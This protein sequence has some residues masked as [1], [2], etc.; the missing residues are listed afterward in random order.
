MKKPLLSL[1]TALVLAGCGGSNGPSNPTAGFDF[2]NATGNF[3]TTSV[4]VERKFVFVL[5]Q[6]DNTV[7]GFFIPEFEEEGHGHA[8][9][10]FL[11]QEEEGEIEF[12]EL[13]GSPYPLTGGT[14]VDLV[15]DP[16]GRYLV[17]VDSAGEL[18]SYAIDGFTGLL[19]LADQ[20]STTVANPRRLAA[21]S[22]GTSVAVLGDQISIHQ[23][24]DEGVFSIGSVADNTA[25]WTD[26][27]LDGANGI[28]ATPAGVEGFQ[29]TTGGTL[30]P[31]FSVALPGATR[32][33]LTFAEAGVF[34]VNRENNSVSQ[35]EQAPNS[36]LTLVD[37]F[38]LPADLTDPVQ[39]VAL[40]DGEDLGV[41]DSDSFCLLHPE[42]G[43]LE[44]E[45]CLDLPRVPNR[46]FALPESNVVFAGHATGNGST[47]IEVS[48]EEL[49]VHPEP[50]PGGN[51][52]FGFGY[53]ERVEIVTET[54]EF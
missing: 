23:V 37:T 22:D 26:V 25:D 10:R 24:S 53:A 11:A 38:A 39:I 19:T 6:N 35:L 48:D 50:G 15:V 51:G 47:Q 28:A 8:H 31:R 41:T 44:D 17:V 21:N 54:S 1:F 36:E 4:E 9:G 12:E 46:L 27:K 34:V 52:P 42:E 33:E 3:I 16:T 32:G 14:A 45:G 30:F 2:D 7:S 49:E 18:R 40:F 20:E 13:D 5:N 43:E 29:W